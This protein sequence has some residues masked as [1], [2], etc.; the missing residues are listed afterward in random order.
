MAGFH[1]QDESGIQSPEVRWVPAFP[2]ASAV[3]ELPVLFPVGGL[4]SPGIANEIMRA[5]P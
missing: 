4:V 1:F 3:G 2:P 5:S